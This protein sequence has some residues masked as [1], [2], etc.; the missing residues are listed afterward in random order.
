MFP[1]RD[2]VNP[3]SFTRVVGIGVGV[4]VGVGA[5][6]VGAAPGVGVRVGQRA[7]EGLAVR[8]VAFAE[9]GF[10]KKSFS[11]TNQT[12]SVVFGIGGG[13]GVS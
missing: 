1:F 6:V 12:G 2:K 5:G 11:K 9:K 4:G 3:N 10:A 13:R 7:H 8:A